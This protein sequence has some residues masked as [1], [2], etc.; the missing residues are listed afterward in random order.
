VDDFALKKTGRSSISLQEHDADQRAGHRA[1]DEHLEIR[2]LTPTAFS[3]FT[4]PLIMGHTHGY[5]FQ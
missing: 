5:R 4:Q 2:D 1:Q 3:F